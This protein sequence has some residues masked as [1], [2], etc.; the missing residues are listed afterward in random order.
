MWNVVE[1][2]VVWLRQLLC[3]VCMK[4]RC[5]RGVVSDKVIGITQLSLGFADKHSLMSVRVAAEPKE[6]LV[7][8]RMTNPS[9]HPVVLYQGTTLEPLLENNV[10]VTQP[11]PS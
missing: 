3:Q 7:P 6:G 1:L 11:H 9:P 5:W 2:H 4:C 8:A 10:T